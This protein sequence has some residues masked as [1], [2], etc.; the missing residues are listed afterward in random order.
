MIPEPTP[1]GADTRC[2]PDVPLPDCL[3]LAFTCPTCKGLYGAVCHVCAV[4]AERQRIAARLL[5]L[6][7]D[8]PP[9]IERQIVRE[10]ADELDAGTL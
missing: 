6:I 3:T 4:V 1:P 8:N 9:Y 10:F 7:E 2:A 5:K